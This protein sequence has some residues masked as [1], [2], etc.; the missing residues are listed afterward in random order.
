[1]KLIRFSCNG[2]WTFE[3]EKSQGHI[4]INLS[5]KETPNSVGERGDDV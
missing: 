4:D 2:Q 3:T 5:R 1:M